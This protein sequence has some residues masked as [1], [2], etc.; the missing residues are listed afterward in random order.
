MDENKL[1]KYQKIDAAEDAVSDSGEKSD[2]KKS[3]KEK[4]KK[5]KPPKEKK[6]KEKKVKEPKPPKEKKVKEPKPPKEKKVKEPK[7]PK[8]KKIKEKKQSKKKHGEGSLINGGLSVPTDIFSGAEPVTELFEE[9]A[10]AENTNVAPEPETEKITDISS[11]S[12]RA[13]EVVL[14]SVTLVS[15]SGKKAKKEKKKKE[16]KVKKEKVKKEKAPKVKKSKKPREPMNIKDFMTIGIALLAVIL[17][18]GIFGYKYYISHDNP[19]LPAEPTTGEDNMAAVQVIRAGS[20][21]N[22]VQSDIP[23][24]FYGFTGNYD[25]MFY[26]YRNNKMVPVKSSGKIEAK[27]D[28]GNQVL[29]VTVEYVKLGDRLFGIGLFRADKNED[30][31]FYNMVLFKL[32][33][34]PKA[35]AAENKALLLASIGDGALRSGDV[36]WSESFTLDLTNGQTS[37]FLK[38]NNRTLD[39][40]GAGVQDFCILTS[41]G[42]KSTASFVPFITAREYAVGSGKQDIYIKEGGSEMLFAAD[43]YGKFLMS[44]G[45]SVYFMRKTASGFDV[46]KKTADTEKVIRSFYGLMSSEYIHSGKYILSKNDGKL[47]NLK[48][49][50]EKTLLGYRMTPQ[51]MTVS[52][53]GKYVVMLGTVNS[54]VDFQ[55]HIFNLETGEYSRYNDK[56]YSNHFN[57]TFVDNKTVVYSVLDPNRGF[58]YVAIDVTKAK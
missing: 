40:N 53:D 42:Y 11:D 10:A 33:N 56:N 25:L 17:A 57:L 29:P 48:T 35:Y 55:V 37:R 5:E 22:L 47:Y 23:D 28:M 32:T 9:P 49:G 19:E 52:P 26:Q 51:M 36:M 24:V 46:I 39:M 30:V 15:E 27:V 2:K 31:Y 8:E 41:E 6:V 58:E 12:R 21:V 1:D 4:V 20:G 16:P 38:V 54:A 13:E 50:D 3:K 43:V 14:P 7:P 34:L 44:E 45:N 18:A